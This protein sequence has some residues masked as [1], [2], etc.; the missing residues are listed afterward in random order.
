MISVDF[1]NVFLRDDGL[2]LAKEV[3]LFCPDA[4]MRKHIVFEKKEWDRYGKGNSMKAKWT[5]PYRE[6]HRVQFKLRGYD[7]LLKFVK[8]L[9]EIYKPILVYDTAIDLKVLQTLQVESN[10][11]DVSRLVADRVGQRVTLHTALLAFGVEHK[12][13]SLHNPFA[14]S[15]YTYKLW[16]KL[17][18][19]E[20]DS[21]I[22]FP[23]R[24]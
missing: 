2:W 9:L 14:D 6:L 18:A 23:S 21:S 22:G 4:N 12:R 13:A 24:L 3:G 15:M 19:P 8:S 10:I 1:E 16:E 7:T 5:N 17:Q 11:I 20:S